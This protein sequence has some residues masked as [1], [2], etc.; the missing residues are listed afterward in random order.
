MKKTVP[1]VIY[2]SNKVRTIVGEIEVDGDTFKGK[3][4]I[5]SETLAHSLGLL[6]TIRPGDLSIEPEPESNLVAH[7]RRE[8]SLCE[9]DPWLI[10][11]IV[12]IVQSFADMG[13]SGGSASI[14]IGIVNELLQYHNLTPLTDDPTDWQDRS[15]ESGYPLWQCRRRSDAFSEDG[16]ATYWLL[17]EDEAKNKIH[18]S[19]PH[20]TDETEAPVPE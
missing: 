14:T 17:N 2:D 5:T 9:S 3:G 19:A 7:A 11:G 4:V 6:D 8:L 10:D 12:K 13:H 20:Q 1:L 16:G 15:V 18:I